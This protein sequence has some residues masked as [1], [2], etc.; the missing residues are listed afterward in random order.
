MTGRGVHFSMAVVVLSGVV[1]AQFGPYGHATTPTSGQQ[2][3]L[4]QARTF[5]E[6]TGEDLSGITLTSADLSGN[7]PA[8]SSGDGT[9]IGIDFDRLEAVV[10]PDT[11]GAPGHPGCVVILVFHELQHLRHGWGRG[12]CAE[13]GITVYTA[14]KHCEFICW[15]SDEGGGPLDALCLMYAHVKQTM[16]DA[17]M[18]SKIN[19]AGCS[20]STTIPDCGCCP[21]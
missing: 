14:T 1:C 10:P 3:S 19:A 2:T 6:S 8:A 11:P 12:F 15:I 20:G 21:N 7:L 5:L 18:Q 17:G 16:N 4:D 9:T 13:V